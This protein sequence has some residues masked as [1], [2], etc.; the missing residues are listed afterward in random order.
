[1]AAEAGSFKMATEIIKVIM[2]S[3]NTRGYLNAYVRV[4]ARLE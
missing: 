2:K 1:M 3:E 4:R